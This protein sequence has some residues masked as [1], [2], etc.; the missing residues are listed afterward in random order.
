MR[1]GAG[2]RRSALGGGDI[3]RQEGRPAAV[4]PLT[5]CLAVGA[6]RLPAA[7]FDLD[8]GGPLPRGDEPD[9]HLGRIRAIALEMPEIAEPARRLPDRDLA[10]VVLEAAGC[11]LEDPTAG[12]RLQDDP[13]IVASDGALEATRAAR[14]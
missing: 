7:V 10:P 5:P 2:K 1:G 6:E 3:P 13:D 11:P 9:F 8:S 12:T 14:A 4:V